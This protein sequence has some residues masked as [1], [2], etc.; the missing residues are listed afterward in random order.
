MYH[1]VSELYNELLGNYFY[2]YK[3]LS[4][5]QKRKLGNKYNPINSVFEAY[6]YE[7]WFE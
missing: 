4:D 2:Q 5:V 3:A 1:T 6:N 7:D